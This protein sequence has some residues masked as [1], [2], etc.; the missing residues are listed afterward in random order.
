MQAI[1]FPLRHDLS[2]R[3]INMKPSEIRELSEE[4][5]HQ[6]ELELIEE[7]FNLNIQHS[8]GQLESTARLDQVRKDIA[9]VKTIVRARALMKGERA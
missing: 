1:S 8:I 3:E 9:R 6:K 7:L 2:P 5:L 4:E